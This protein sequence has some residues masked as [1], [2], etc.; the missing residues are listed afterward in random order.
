[1]DI[2]L[3]KLRELNEK[4]KNHSLEFKSQELR[5]ENIICIFGF[6]LNSKSKQVSSHASTLIDLEWLG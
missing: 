3:I 2:H 4:K 5:S 6:F 1:M